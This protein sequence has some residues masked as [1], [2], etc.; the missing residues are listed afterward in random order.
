M[1]MNKKLGVALALSMVVGATTTVPVMAETTKNPEKTTK[2]TT[3]SATD[4]RKDANAAKAEY[5]KAAAASKKAD[6]DLAAAQKAAANAE[7]EH[8]AAKTAKEKFEAWQTKKTALNNVIEARKEV[9]KTESVTWYK[10]YKTAFETKNGQ[11]EEAKND[12]ATIE[13]NNN[14]TPTYARYLELKDDKDEKN[15][16]FEE[17]CTK[18]GLDSNAKE[19]SID[20][21]HRETFVSLKNASAEADKLFD[22]TVGHIED[23]ISKNGDY[24]NAIQKAVRIQREII[25]M[26]DYITLVETHNDEVKA[27]VKALEDEKDAE[28]E[29][30][31]AHNAYLE[32]KKACE[33]SFDSQ[34]EWNDEV[35]KLETAKNTANDVLT[36]KTNAANTAKQTAKAKK[37]AYDKAEQKAVAAEKAEEALRLAEEAR[38][39]AKAKPAKVTLKKAKS[40][41]RK[42]VK[43]TWKKAKAAKTYQVA[44]R[45]K[46]KAHKWTKWTYKVVRG[47]SY[48][49]KKLKSKKVY[50][51]KVRGLNGKIK[52]AFSKKKKV[53]VK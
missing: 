33:K 28:K 43:V 46:K 44:Y 6:Q 10:E 48:T 27:Y 29:E 3:K 11:L 42:T 14:L 1:K 45:R 19:N 38:K 26:N 21:E 18:N 35:N 50:Q 8:T 51:F 31:D 41:K 32:A 25:N 5:D 24:L 22:E 23:N 2:D 39:A 37:A 53:R 36:K 40:K 52:G 4:L 12:V 30:D 34:E 13:K 17:F 7:K 15:K 20:E 16:A 49:N 9:E 47:T